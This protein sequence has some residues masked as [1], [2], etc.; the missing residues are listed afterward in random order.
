M[1]LTPTL[2]RSLSVVIAILALAAGLGLATYLRQPPTPAE[3]LLQLKLPDHAGKQQSLAQW[4]NTI[5]VVNFWATWC[6]P[7]REEMPMLAASAIENAGNGVQFV[8]IALDTPEAVAD[9]AAKTPTPYPL[10]QAGMAL[11]PLMAALGNRSQ[12]LP[13]TAFIDRQGRLAQ[14]KTGP[15]TAL[16]LQAILTNLH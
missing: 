1:K 10:F 7:C 8:G 4:P 9:Y 2:R 3:Q 12:G 14:I 16:E 11:G 13:F 6:P 15:L 5:R